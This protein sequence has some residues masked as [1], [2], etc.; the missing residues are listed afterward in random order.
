VPT[1]SM[2]ASRAPTS[3]NWTWSSDGMRDGASWAL[4]ASGANVFV[5][6]TWAGVYQSSNNGTLWAAAN[7][8]LP[9]RRI[10]CLTIS[11]DDLF[12]GTGGGVWRRGISGPTS[13]EFASGEAP[14]QFGLEQ[15]YPNPFNPKT[16]LG[17]SVGVVS[18]QRSADSSQ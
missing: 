11:G 8:S 13:V 15:N 6:T 7:D 18:S 16:S 1:M 10:Y 3:W 14:V 2:M 4:A 17:Y 12:V 5:G 9:Y